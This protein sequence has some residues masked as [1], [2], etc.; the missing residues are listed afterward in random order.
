[1]KAGK[2]TWSKDSSL[3][4]K[5]LPLFWEGWLKQLEF[6]PGSSTLKPP[7]KLTVGKGSMA[8]TRP[9]DST[10]HEAN[11]AKL[12]ILAPT[13]TTVSPVQANG[14]VSEAT[15]ERLQGFQLHTN[16][17]IIPEHRPASV[18]S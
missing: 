11:R 16:V 8:T 2:F 3:E 15:L 1:M 9:F 13:S 5:P 10:R 12:P 4:S 7:A 14:Y 6:K 18:P 17:E